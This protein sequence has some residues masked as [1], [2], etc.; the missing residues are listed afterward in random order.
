M[1][2]AILL[3]FVL[4]PERGGQLDIQLRYWLPFVGAALVMGALIRRESVLWSLL[5]LLLTGFYVGLHLIA[6]P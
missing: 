5:G 1:T 6:I 2:P 4:G 3:P